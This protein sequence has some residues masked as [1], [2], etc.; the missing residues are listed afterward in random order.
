M[1]HP[2]HTVELTGMGESPAVELEVTNP[3][4]PVV[5]EMGSGLYGPA[6]PTGPAGAPG[7]DS[8]V[9]G[10][11]GPT[12]PAGPTGAAGADG[13]DG[14]DGLGVVLLEAGVTTPPPG[15]PDGTIVYRKVS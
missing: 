9:V 4:Y 11:T 13:A 7:A 1:T 12:G 8:T 14:A 10:P 3:R 15:T 6:G 2:P 5:I